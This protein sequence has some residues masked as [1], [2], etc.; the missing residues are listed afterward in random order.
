MQLVIFNSAYCILGFFWIGVDFIIQDA[1]K[2]TADFHIS[3]LRKF[4]DYHHSQHY[5]DFDIY[6]L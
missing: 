4:V 2:S 5:T 1:V 3:R 6:V